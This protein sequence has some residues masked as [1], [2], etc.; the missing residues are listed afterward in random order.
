MILTVPRIKSILINHIV[1]NSAKE[2][3]REKYY[4]SLL[5]LFVPFRNESKLVPQGE[6]PETA[7]NRHIMSNV[8]MQDYH[9]KLS[10]SLECHKMINKARAKDPDV[11]QDCNDDEKHMLDDGGPTNSWACC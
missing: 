1:Y 7:F 8:A 5:L 3:Q 2:E 6:T 9:K 11:T 10:K 4:Y